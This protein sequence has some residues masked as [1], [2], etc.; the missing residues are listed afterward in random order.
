M[1]DDNG[2]GD[3]HHGGEGRQQ[4]AQPRALAEQLAI[5]GPE[6]VGDLHK[7]ILD[8]SLSGTDPHIRG[9]ACLALSCTHCHYLVQSR[10]GPGR[11]SGLPAG[12]LLMA[13]LVLGTGNRHGAFAKAA[14]ERIDGVHQAG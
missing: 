5:R 14:V 13:P 11:P 12:M 10:R 6:Q 7:L 4:P 2:Q 8:Q 1:P 3:Q 9:A